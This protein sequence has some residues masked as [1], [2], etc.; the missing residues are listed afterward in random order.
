MRNRRTPVPLMA[1]TMS[2][3]RAER[4]PTKWKYRMAKR[5]GNRELKKPKQS[6][7]KGQGASSVAELAKIS[8][9]IIGKKR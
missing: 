5:N 2:V 9:S 8:A 4:F 6:K 7:P 1:W 3:R